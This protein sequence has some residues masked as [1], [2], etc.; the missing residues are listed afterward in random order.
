L[1]S[2]ALKVAI[3]HDWLITYGGAERVVDQLHR[4]F[5]DA[6]IYTLIYDK[7]KMPER[8]RTYDI[9]TT[10]LQ[11]IPFASKL[12]KNM[13]TLMPGAFER[14]NLMEYDLVI[15]S[16]SSCSKGV[17]TRSDAVHICYCHTPTRYIWDFYYT[18]L[19]NAGWIK[20]LFIPRLIQKMRLWDRLAADRVDHFIANSDYIAQRIRKY[21]HRESTVIYPCVHISEIQPVETPGD[22]YLTVGRFAYYKRIDIAI[23]ACN[24]LG[25]K[26]VIVGGGDE[27]KKL[28]AMA[29]STIVFKGTVSDEEVRQ[30]YNRAKAFLFPGEEDFGITPV[31]AQSAGCPVLAYGRGGALETVADGKTGLFFMEQIEQSLAECIER[32]EQTGV[33]CTRAQIREHSLRFSEER[34]RSEILEYCEKTVQENHPTS[35]FVSR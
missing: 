5:P 19:H 28:R 30:L 7:N 29:G 4:I 8:F 23:R 16:S 17:L 6:P 25:K 31:E 15:S 13:L 12:Y 3:V 24:R 1:H 32:F 11:K 35:V 22:Y 34:F 20:R 18:Y 2:E 9:R 33:A 26:L 10:Y 14:L 21:Y 27:D